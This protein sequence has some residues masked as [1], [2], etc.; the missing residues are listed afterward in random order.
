MMGSLVPPSFAAPGVKAESFDHDPQW[1]G[2][3]NHL[4][5]AKY[6]AVT[7]DFGYSPT[8]FAGNDKGEIGGRVT[9][10]AKPAYYGE[11]I[12][13]KTLDDKLTAS[14][15]F[16]LTDTGGSGGLFFGWFNANQPGG[17]GRPMNS[18]GLDF[19]GEK[20]GARLAVRLIGGTN[21]AC[22]TFITPFIPGKF[23]PTPLKANG[24]RYTW[25]LDYDPLANHGNGRFLFTI[26]SD[27]PQELEAGKLPADL[28]EPYRKEALSHYPNVTTFSVDVPAE[29]RK[30]GARFDHFGLMNLMKAGGPMTVYFSDLQHDG[31]KATLAQDPRWEGSGNHATY[32]DRE[33]AGTQDFG[34]TPTNFAGGKPGEIGGIIWRGGR[35]AYYA[36]R[37]GPLSL[38]DRLEASGKVVLKVGAP[39]SDIYIGWF[40]SANKTDS[41]AKSG[42]FLGIHVGGPT[43]IGHY[44]QPMLLTAKG[45][46]G[47]ADGGP[48]LT[49]N[50]VYDWSLLYDPA[51]E[52]GRGVIRATLGE[53][54]V[55]LTLRKNAKA[56]GASFDRFGLFNL[57]EGG[58]LVK[59]YLDDLKYTAGR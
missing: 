1:E 44:F 36:D 16:T 30:S 24:A 6:P 8:S 19:D 54:S 53:E 37:V 18:L 57:A 41:P 47:R 14:G 56:E 22:G 7:Q 38:N 3:N 13:V 25:T 48:I 28:P 27:K 9:R 34:F 46:R 31:K 42:N 29:V 43:R 51:A 59:I 55:T 49:P 32:E 58:Q 11:K 33:P 2:F 52:G 10:A 40:N 5:P 23:R 20:T 35:Y 21:R 39:D 45:T 12:G 4:V 26:K 17:G 15:T 50:K